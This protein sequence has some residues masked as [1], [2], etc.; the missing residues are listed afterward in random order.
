MIIEKKESVMR[1]ISI[2]I[3]LICDVCKKEYKISGEHVTK[4]NDEMEIQEF[5]RINTVGGYNSV[6]GDG[7]EIKLDMCQKCFNEKLGEF[8][9]K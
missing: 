8:V 2:P 6:F 3:G 7:R 1:E 4:I 9:Q 5:V